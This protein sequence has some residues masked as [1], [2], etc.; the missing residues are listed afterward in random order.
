M[1]RAFT[2]EDGWEEPVVAPRAPLPDGTPNY[3]TP[4]GLALLQAEMAA[5][6][7]ERAAIESAEVSDDERRRRRAVHA[8][9][10]GELAGRLAMAQLVEP[11]AGGHDAVR[12]G[13]RVLVRDA[14]GEES[15]YT[16]VGV[17]EADPEEGRVAFTSPIARAL[18]GG[19]VGQ[20]VALKTGRGEEKLT[21]VTIDSPEEAS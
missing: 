17:D 4:R 10:A 9:R 7:A 14:R 2:K 19:R 12:F 15:R 13:A 18:L 3:V 20:V 11:P 6:D 21:I 5:L 16:I 8:H 1:S